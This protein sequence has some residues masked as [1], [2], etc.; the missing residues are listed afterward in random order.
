MDE[1]EKIMS[2]LRDSI[3]P[4]YNPPVLGKVIKAY[5]GPGNTAYSV[6][7]RIL[8]AGSLEESDLV[9]PAVPINPIWTG[10][11]GKGLY[12]IPPENTIV[13]VGF[14]EW[15]MS[16]PYVAGVWSDNYKTGEFKKGQLMITDGQGLKLGVDVDSLFLFET[17]QHSLKSIL[18]ELIDE[19]A[20]LKTQGPPPSH[21]VSPVSIQK[22]QVIKT[23]IAQLLK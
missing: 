18:D 2:R 3:F 12:A 22:L 19:V 8:K 14:I 20:A 16:F 7:V 17:K 21:V 4:N 6:D 9:L 15:D 1:T 23:K 11:G 10:Q 13:I 5:E